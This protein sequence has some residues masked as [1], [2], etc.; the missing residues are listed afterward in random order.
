MTEH[1]DQITRG[2]AAIRAS[3]WSEAHEILSELDRE[4][5]LS[6]EDVELLSTASF[7]LGRI[8][9]ML[10]ALERAHQA[11][12][13][14]DDLFPA[15]RTAVWLGTHLASRGKYAQASG[16]L[17]RA[18]R[19][20]EP[21]DED[22]LERGY[23][24]LPA[25]FKHIDA[26][27]YEEAA[28][29]ASEAASIG[30]RFRDDDL[31]ALAMHAQGRALVRQGRAQDGLRLL[32]EA[33]VA[34]AAVQLSPMVTGLVYCSV[35]EGCY[36][37]GEIRR[38][39]EWTMALST[40]CDAQPDLVAFTDQC[41]AHRAEIM[42]L[43]GTWT[44]ALE[45]A[46]RAH[47]RKGGGL[48]AA[49]AYYQQA[50]IHRLR[51]DYGRAEDDYRNVSRNGGDP[52]PG[53][54]RLRL[55]QGDMAAAGASLERALSETADPIQRFS[56][57]PAYVD[58]MLSVGDIAAAR[59][60]CDELQAVADQTGIDMHQA[61]SSYA[62]GVVDLADGR[63]GEAIPSLRAAFKL[64]QTLG[65]PHEMA[66]TRTSLGRALLAVGD[67]DTARLELEAA[68]SM[69][70]QLGAAPDLV[71]V[72]A[73][74]RTGGSVKPHDLTPRELEVLR[75]LASGATNRSIAEHLVLS[76][77]TVDRH[78]SNIFA[79]LGVT[80]RSAA[81]SYAYRHQLV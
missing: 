72:E 81:T 40:W 68:R 43:Q 65:V 54:A 55:A 3:K 63:P 60:A 22:R 35:I 25:V 56:V 2:R 12:L 14:D 69:F 5:G 57:L 78:V 21:V 31:V 10:S 64:W 73:L 77:R 79:K 75:L 50:E 16:W 38:A 39:A 17:E 8:D 71:G 42:Q 48:I 27:E 34:V 66:R 30:R 49:Q 59:K 29:V 80:T 45:Q 6:P 37:I 53:L 11:Y 76:E 46:R 74:S 51:G 44:E 70:A 23:M 36:E 26:E 61:R 32:D 47:Q 1:G 41:L 13:D 18:H 19:L 52:Q 7:M 62:R 15:V 20:M 24:L 58:V 28:A 33:M 67:E 9:E 4:K